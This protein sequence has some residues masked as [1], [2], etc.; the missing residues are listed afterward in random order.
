MTGFRL[1]QRRLT[2][3]P[4][5]PS[6]MHPEPLIGIA[7]HVVFNDLVEERGI[8]NGSA[9]GSPVR[10]RSTAG[11]NSTRYLRST[12]SQMVNAGTTAAPVCSATRATPL[13]VQAGTPYKF[14]NTPCGGVMLVSIR[15][16]TVS[17]LRM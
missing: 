12:G 16:P 17:L 9:S 6:P 1:V 10:T 15:T 14:T 11:L 5:L 2:W 3:R 4:S 13:A 7:A 8:G